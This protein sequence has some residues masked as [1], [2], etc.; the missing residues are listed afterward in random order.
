MWKPKQNPCPFDTSRLQRLE[1]QFLSPR[2]RQ[3]KLNISRLLEKDGMS[4]DEGGWDEESDA[5]GVSWDMLQPPVLGRII[6][7]NCE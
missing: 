6:K 3:R 4:S 1:R 5:D 7:V 2:L